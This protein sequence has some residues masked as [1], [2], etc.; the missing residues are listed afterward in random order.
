M[1][2]GDMKK[3]SDNPLSGGLGLGYQWHLMSKAYKAFDMVTRHSCWVDA[4]EA[5]VSSFLIDFH[6]LRSRETA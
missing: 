6:G 1:P 4:P 2:H 3:C 5:L